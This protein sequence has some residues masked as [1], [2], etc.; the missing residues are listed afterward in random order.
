MWVVRADGV[1]DVVGVEHSAAVVG[2]GV[3]RDAAEHRGPRRLGSEN[4][5]FISEDD[6]VAALGVGQ[7]GHEVAHSPA[8]HKDRGLLAQP[9]RGHRLQRVD[10]GVFAVHVIAQFSLVHRSAHLRRGLGHGVASKIDQSHVV[11]PVVRW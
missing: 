1:S 2:N 5:R 4:V 10:L 9:L 6:L 3:V 8:C 11:T 7:D